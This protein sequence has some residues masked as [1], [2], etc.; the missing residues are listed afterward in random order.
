VW[1]TLGNDGWN[2][3]TLFP[4]YLKS[5]SLQV[6]DPVR[7]ESSHLQYNASVH[8]YSGPLKTGWTYGQTNSSLPVT[9]NETYLSLGLPWN[10]DVNTGD[11][12]G[13]SV[14]PRTVDQE[15][16]VRADAAR[17]YY[18]PFADRTNLKVLLNTAATKVNWCESTINSTSVQANGVHVTYQ[19]GTT[20]VIN[21]NKEVVLSAGALVSPLLLELSGVGNL[22]ILSQYGIETVIDLPTVGENLQDQMNNGLQYSLSNTS[23]ATL[24]GSLTYVAYPNAQHLFG[25]S[26]S[27]VAA[28]VASA[29]PAYASQVAAVNNNVTSESD[30]LAFFQLQHDLIFKDLIP[31]AEVLVNQQ[32][33]T[34]DSEYWALL[35]FSRGSVHIGSSNTTAGAKINPNYF[36]LDWDVHSQVQV[37]RFIRELYAAEP[38]AALIGEETSPGLQTVPASAD[39]DTWAAWLKQKY[40][41]NFHPVGTAG[42]LPKEKGGV[43]DTELKVYGTANVRVV[44]ASVLPMQVCGHLVSTLYAVAERAADLILQ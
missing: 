41:S 21:V 27:L 16:D 39:D 22:S 17:A 2:W 40:R 10:E 34:W 6:P 42:M 31:A 24:N 30:L 32:S 37:A 19:D 18:Y 29:L 11:M 8:G 38:F 13:H 12:V 5:E 23:D 33:G 43:V 7:A 25:N 20:G 28:S 15:L 26:T 9:L 35:P 36:M 44:D 1:E 4:Y 14:F 3:D